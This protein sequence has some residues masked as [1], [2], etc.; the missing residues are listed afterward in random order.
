MA[1]T[2][3]EKIYADIKSGKFISE[4]TSTSQSIEI[5]KYILDEYAKQQSI[6]FANFLGNYNN[7]LGI[8]PRVE[9]GIVTWYFINGESVGKGDTNSVYEL[10]IS[11]EQK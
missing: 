5:P 8:T 3:E 9:K 7:G 1:L 10:F 2:K 4:Q 11:K 6:E